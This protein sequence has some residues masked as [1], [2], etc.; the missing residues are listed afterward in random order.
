VR[1][2]KELRKDIRRILLLSWCRI[3]NP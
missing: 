2:R 3:L 1:P